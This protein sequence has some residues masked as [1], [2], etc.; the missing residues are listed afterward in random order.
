MFLQKQLADAKADL[1][2]FREKQTHE[3]HLRHL[4]REQQ[5]GRMLRLENI[6]AACVEN[7][8]NNGGVPHSLK[9]MIEHD[10][11][12][13]L[14]PMEGGN[15]T[16]IN[17]HANSASMGIGGPSNI[18]QQA[19]TPIRHQNAPDSAFGNTTTNMM[20]NETQERWKGVHP[21]YKEQYLAT[22]TIDDLMAEDQ[23]ML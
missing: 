5:H 2:S 23:N 9:R 14:S 8:W 10:A 4:E 21:W 18:P 16:T 7:M 17:V 11:P 15:Q 13:A 3:D 6:I 22:Y 12:G 19:L 20:A 1:Q